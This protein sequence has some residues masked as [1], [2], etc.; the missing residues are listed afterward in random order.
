[1]QEIYMADPTFINFVP[2]TAAEAVD[3][4]TRCRRRGLSAYRIPECAIEC[5]R[6]LPPHEMDRFEQ[7]LINP[8]NVD[9]V[10]VSPNNDITES[11]ESV[12]KEVY[13]R[14]YGDRLQAESFPPIPNP[15]DIADLTAQESSSR[16]HQGCEDE[17]APDAEKLPP[18][19]EIP[20]DPPSSAILPASTPALPPR[21]VM[22]TPPPP[23]SP[24]CAAL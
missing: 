7:W 2:R 14:V 22:A 20:A 12:R 15:V 8:T 21:L 1:M 9:V 17:K 18:V 5:A 16:Y 6:S 19:P 23:S 10:N 11:N 13:D 4:F 3:R 24:T